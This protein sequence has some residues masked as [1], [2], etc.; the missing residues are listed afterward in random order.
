M[1]GLTGTPGVPCTSTAA[2]SW[3]TTVDDS[4]SSSAPW[5]FT[6][7][8]ATKWT[9]IMLKANN[10]GVVPVNGNS[11]NATQIC[12]DG[13]QQLLLPANYVGKNCGPSHKVLTV[14][15]TNPGNGYTA[16]PVITIDAPG[17]R[18]NAGNRH[19]A[20]ATGAQRTDGFDSRRRRRQLVL[21]PRPSVTISGGGG[22]GATAVA[23]IVD[24][25]APVTFLTLNS[26]GQQ[27]FTSAPSVAISGGQG[28]GATGIATVQAGYN[29]IYSITFG[30]IV[31]ATT[32]SVSP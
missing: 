9:R 25:G 27:C 15:V 6:T 29:C 7:P 11:A 8:L 22:S 31:P 28:S 20:L 23:E 18:G 4:Q 17:C 14:V 30:A 10:M 1:L 21:R 24:P 13:V 3:Y 12:W 16:Q 19:C 26:P 5:N 2:G 32:A